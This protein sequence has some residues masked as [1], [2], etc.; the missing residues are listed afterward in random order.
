M[1][2]L[3]PRL[4]L[5]DRR[6]GHAKFPSEVTRSLAFICTA[7]NLQSLSLS[8]LAI[9]GAFTNCG[10]S[11]CQ[12]VSAIHG[13]RDVF[14]VGDV[15]IRLVSI[16]VIHAQLFWARANECLRNQDMNVMDPAGVLMPKVYDRVAVPGERGA[17]QLEGVS[18]PHSAMVAD[19][20]MW[21]S[22][23][24]PFF[25]HANN[26]IS[27]AKHAQAAAYARLAA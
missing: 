12:R 21:G 3:P 5:A 20:V 2:P 26:V 4:Y 23:S 27:E 18:T 16:L 7:A 11:G 14:K 22:G 10:K 24:A 17:L 25:A 6:L 9:P 15:V 13:I 19:F 8:Q 1:T